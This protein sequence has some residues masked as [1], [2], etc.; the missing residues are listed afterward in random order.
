MCIK[1]VDHSQ[2][3]TMSQ[4]LQL[5]MPSMGKRGGVSR[6]PATHLRV[7]TKL[8][9][10]YIKLASLPAA[11]LNPSPWQVLSV[12][13]RGRDFSQDPGVI[14]IDDCTETRKREAFRPTGT[15]PTILTFSRIVFQYL[16]RQL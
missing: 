1:A 12:D 13:F 6:S 9:S 14:F 8:D 10:C 5:S 16:A 2:A 4:Q 3:V 15:N 11:R 7:H